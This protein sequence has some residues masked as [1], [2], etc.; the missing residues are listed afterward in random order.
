MASCPSYK[1]NTT[2]FPLSSPVTGKSQN[3]LDILVESRSRNCNGK[4]LILENRSFPG[5]PVVEN[6]TCNAEDLGS[7]PGWELKSH[8][9]QS[10]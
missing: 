1:T 3:S 7:I 5:G 4:D 8:M 10:Y 2:S 9:P 6:L